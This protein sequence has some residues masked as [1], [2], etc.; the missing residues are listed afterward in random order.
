MKL[1]LPKN[2]F[3]S[4]FASVI[5]CNSEIEIV[6]KESA[7]LCGQLDSDT[8]AVALVPSL[9]LINHRSLF[10]SKSLAFSFDG[11]LSNSYLS[12]IEK[13]KNIS[14]IK[15]RGDV[16]INEI[17][18]T[19]ILFSERYSTEIEISLDPAKE[20]CIDKNYIIVGDEN[21]YSG[22]Y[23]KSISFADQIAELID[24]PYVNYVFVSKDIESLKKFNSLFS[25]IDSQIED[26]HLPVLSKLQ[27]GDEINNF[28]SENIGSVYFEMTQNEVNALN[29]LIRLAYYHGIIED[30]FDIRFI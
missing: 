27:Y 11:I 16:S 19:K 5:P 20:K 26:N 2:I 18:L 29:E 13:E 9:E 14:E 4:I 24:L 17:I 15:S 12:F 7:M 21:F 28:V 6:Y 3:S 22:E 25:N 30:I 10:V 1:F 8:S 23:S